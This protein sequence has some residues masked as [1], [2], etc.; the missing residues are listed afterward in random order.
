MKGVQ[1]LKKGIIWRVGDGSNINI[2]SDPWIPRGI[3]R[4]VSSHKGRHLVTRVNELINPV[5]NSWDTDLVYQ[6]FNADDAETILK[7]PILENTN[8]FIAWHFDKKC[9]FSVKSAYRVAAD[10]AKRDSRHGLPSCSEGTSETSNFNWKKIWALPLPNKVLHFLWRMVTH[11]LP[12]KT[13]LKHRGVEVDTRCP[14]CYR[15]DEDGGHC[16]LKCKKVK[17]IWRMAQMEHTRLKL[18]Q[19]PDPFSLF[20]EVF[21]LEE[22]ERIKEHQGKKYGQEATC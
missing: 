2:W 21:Q 20:E 13:R 4:R 16:F 6:T 5:M 7:I 14:V 9:V 12:L 22:E 18:I 3:T 10:S 1:L 15:F 17:N 11:S 8:D 19:C